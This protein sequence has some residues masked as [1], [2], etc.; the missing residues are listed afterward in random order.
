MSSWLS[1][2]GLLQ[3]PVVTTGH[4]C[5]AWAAVLGILFVLTHVVTIVVT[6]ANKGFGWGAPA[7]SADLT[8]FFAGAG[9]A[10]LCWQSSNKRSSDFKENRW[11]CC[12]ATITVFVRIL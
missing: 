2:R 3:A 8:G 10:S 5:I 7:W 4:K 12:W 6:C 9:F 11:I 1:A